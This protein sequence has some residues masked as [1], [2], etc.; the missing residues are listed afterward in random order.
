MSSLRIGTSVVNNDEVELTLT[1]R[2]TMR[3][4]MLLGR[5]AMQRRL[6]VDPSRSY[7][8]G[9]RPPRRRSQA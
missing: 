1:N 9:G 2:D 6:L 7:L 8:L 5:T 4:R 3:F